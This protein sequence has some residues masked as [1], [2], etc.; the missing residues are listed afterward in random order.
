MK[1]HMDLNFGGTIPEKGVRHLELTIIINL[2]FIN[3]SVIQHL[4]CLK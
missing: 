2:D 3:H 1:F 4:V